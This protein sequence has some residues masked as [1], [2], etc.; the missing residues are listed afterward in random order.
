MLSSN[1][2]LHPLFV[3][4]EARDAIFRNVTSESISIQDSDRFRD[5]IDLLKK[6]IPDQLT[7]FTAEDSKH[8]VTFI[9]LVQK[10]STPKGSQYL[11]AI[12]DQL[13]DQD[14]AATMNALAR[15]GKMDDLA[16]NL[17]TELVGK[18]PNKDENAFVIRTY[19]LLLG[20]ILSHRDLK[21]S[22]SI[23]NVKKSFRDIL[24]EQLLNSDLRTASLGLEGLKRFL[25]L[26]EN[27]ELFIEKGG[28][29]LLIKHLQDANKLSQN[30]TTYH[31]LFCIWALSFSPEGANQL[32][33]NDFVSI[34]GRMLS[35]QSVKSETE[36]IIRLMVGIIIQLTPN[37]VFI[38]SAYDNDVLR[39]LN[40][41]QN[42]QYSD[43]ELKENI[44]KALV[45]LRKQ[46]QHLS[47]WDKY[48][49]EVKSGILRMT[50]SHKAEQF[51][52]DN[53]DRFGEHNFEVLEDLR[54]LLSSN[55]EETVIVA[56]HD[57]G[58]FAHRSPVGRVKLDE[59]HAKTEVMKLI[60]HKSPA[61]Q[62]EALRTTQYL[63]L[64][65]Q[66]A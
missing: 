32:S 63:L 22:K 33:T 40:S 14:F 48:V 54:N 49:R 64:R 8:P 12:I 38:G 20:A 53:I 30:D 4:L 55:D 57:L 37:I 42:K 41:Y 6:P 66:N 34:L 21:V 35:A 26:E 1:T 45:E 51:W 15:T 31:I 2:S 29:K 59:I 58:E 65:N 46:Q 43:K 52:K 47:L 56:C 18:I 27:R 61:V 11:C 44:N 23:N 17:N 39:Y 5:F 19:A 10:I 9:K 60:E 28:I 36:I 13:L 7:D 62:R 16:K 25:V 24:V 3:R 50:A